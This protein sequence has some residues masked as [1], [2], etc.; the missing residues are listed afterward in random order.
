MNEH[1]SICNFITLVNVCKNYELQ[2]RKCSVKWKLYSALYFIVRMTNAK[3]YYYN[4]PLFTTN[5][6]SKGHTQYYVSL[7]THRHAR[8][9]T[10]THTNTQIRTL[11][12]K[13]A[14]RV[15]FFS[16]VSF[17]GSKRV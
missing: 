3:Y 17:F 6:S 5:H 2:G 12:N 11:L 4:L 13:I 8:T 7:Y 16:L 15:P 9:R 14:P 10:H 1:N